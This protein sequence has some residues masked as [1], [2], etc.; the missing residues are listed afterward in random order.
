[1]LSL[2]WAIR[3]MKL[4]IVAI[5]GMPGAGKSTAAQGLVSL[6]WKR[7]VMGDIIREEARR[8]GLEPDSKNTGEVMKELRA[9]M[10]DSAVAKLSLKQMEGLGSDR[11]VV[12][13]ISSVEGPR[14]CS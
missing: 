3:S 10:G 6:G 5:T 8:R 14:S 11:V 9:S 7:I 1:M 4:L 13:G 2:S 12:D